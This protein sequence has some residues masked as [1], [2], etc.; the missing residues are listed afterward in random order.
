MKK[1]ALVFI[2]TLLLSCGTEK[3]TV[4]RS[5]KHETELL[6]IAQ[7]VFSQ[8]GAA[9]AIDKANLADLELTAK[10]KRLLHRKLKFGNITAVYEYKAGDYTEIQT[11]SVVV[12]S[13]T[14][15]F[16]SGAD[17]VA[18]MHKKPL[19]NLPV[20]TPDCCFKLTERLYAVRTSAFINTISISERQDA[21]GKAVA[22]R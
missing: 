12:F 1:L 8:Y 15:M 7:K 9:S 19:G 21:P 16:N 18:D 10:E 4:R 3:R 13:R 20:N 11:D 14:G 2:T 5:L 17:I 22:A 6:T